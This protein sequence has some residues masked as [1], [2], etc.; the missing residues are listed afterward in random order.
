MHQVLKRFTV[1]ITTDFF[2]TELIAFLKQ[3]IN[4]LAGYVFIFRHVN[5]RA[6]K[7]GVLAF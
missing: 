1:R 3:L 4:R 7:D 2:E 6:L 5:K